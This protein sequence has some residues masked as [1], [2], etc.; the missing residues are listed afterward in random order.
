MTT[1]QTA[2]E[3]IAATLRS[4]ITALGT[5]PNTKR[6]IARKSGT[7]PNTAKAQAEHDFA[8]RIATRVQ[9]VAIDDPFYQRKVLRIFL[10]AVI[11]AELGANL[12]NDVRF[13]TLIDSVQQQMESDP[14]LNAMIGSALT[15]LAHS[16]KDNP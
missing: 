10:E 15:A 7:K 4:Q 9:S 12:A 13:A 16:N 6:I 2:T 3:Q 14:E 5:V 1:I 8:D 11:S